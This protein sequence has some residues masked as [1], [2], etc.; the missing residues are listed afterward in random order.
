MENQN[1]TIVNNI[2]RICS[3]GCQAKS[4]VQTFSKILIESYENFV[5]FNRQRVVSS[6][7]GIVI[8][9]VNDDFNIVIYNDGIEEDLDDFIYNFVMNL[10]RT[11]IIN[12][13]KLFAYDFSKLVYRMYPE[14]FLANLN[15]SYDLHVLLNKPFILWNF[16]IVR[17]GT[18]YRVVKY[19]N[20]TEREISVKIP[21]FITS[22]GESVFNNQ[23]N[24][25]KVI[26][27]DGLMH[28]GKSAFSNTGLREVSIPDT[29]LK[30][31]KLAFAS[32]YKLKHIKFSKN[33]EVIEFGMLIYSNSLEKVILPEKLKIIKDAAFSG[34]GIT[35]IN[36]PK[37][38]EEIASFAFSKCF[39][40]K[41]IDLPNGL[42]EI[43]DRAFYQTSLN[44]V[45]IPGSVKTISKEAF[46][47]C[48]D[49]KQVIFQDG[50]EEIET[51]A[52]AN[53]AIE[54][55]VLPDSVKDIGQMAF[56]TI[57]TP[58]HVYLPAEMTE[59]HDIKEIFEEIGV[60]RDRSE[61]TSYEC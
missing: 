50:I 35:N 38:I 58:K 49:L 54:D 42:K 56:A 61:I 37:G 46:N 53:T 55:I 12:P 24:L 22:I 36:L 52:F 26:I 45:V 17:E 39:N 32:N 5:Q 14:E 44:V 6:R 15:N 19:H 2:Q 1:N 8:H 21:D 34:S 16:E 9:E 13:Y 25:K 18:D 41:S 11:H 40:L 7:D 60:V 59:S 28:I 10:H 43:G 27:P 3:Q 4:E 30:I 57:V 23:T 20:N 31:D 33:M 47:F 51:A 48:K 29:V